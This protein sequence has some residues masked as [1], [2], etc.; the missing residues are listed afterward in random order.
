MHGK[1]FLFTECFV[2]KSV[3]FVSVRY[4]SVTLNISEIKGLQKSDFTFW[5]TSTQMC[6]C[7][8]CF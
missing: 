7:F 4:F 5:F 2:Y 6:V 1:L 3:L 8:L